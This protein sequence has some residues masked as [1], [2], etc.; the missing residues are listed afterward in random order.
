MMTGFK[1]LLISGSLAAL[2]TQTAMAS[3]SSVDAAL[4]AGKLTQAINEY[5]SL[6]SSDSQS[7]TGQLLWARILLAQ[8]KTEKAY[9]LMEPLIEKA[10]NNVD[11]QFR[12]GQSAMIMAQK[13]SIFSKLGYAKDGVKAWDAALKIDADHKDTL[14][15]LIGFH[16]FAPGMAG[17][18]IDKALEYAKHLQKID[19]VAGTASLVGVYQSMDKKNLALQEL[20][21]GIKRY[22]DSSRLLFIRAMKHINDEEWNLAHKDLI[23]ALTHAADDMEKSNALYQ[24]AKVAVKSG[25]NVKQA[26]DHVTQL[27]SIEEH[28][29]PQWGNLRLA[30]LYV[31]DDDLPKANSALK[32]VDDSDDDDLED[33]VKHL[34]KRIKKLSK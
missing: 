18:D 4:K 25:K 28:R 2:M 21:E 33:E 34:K 16:R 17:G 10:P 23:D 1:R 12:F 9:D 24:L 29:Y 6:E 19:G 7:I 13:A 15:G 8:D 30:Q 27:M 26:I 3:Q 14:N 22:S 5:K 11:L 31:A 20:N 32:L